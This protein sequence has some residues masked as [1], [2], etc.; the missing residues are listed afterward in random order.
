MTLRE[1]F[2]KCIWGEFKTAG[3]DV[4]Y[5]V[6]Q[7]GPIYR[8]YLQGTES[9]QDVIQDA[10]F[11]A[12]PYAQGFRVHK[13]IAEAYLSARGRI[14]ADLNAAQAVE[15][16][17][18]SLGAALAILLYYDLAPTVAV[19][20]FGFGTPAILWGAPKAVRAKFDRFTR[21]TLRGDPFAQGWLPPRLLGYQH[22]GREVT[23]GKPHRLDA[24]ARHGDITAYQRELDRLE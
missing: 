24:F 15:V 19:R 14:L 16:H 13:G 8:V 3:L 9:L 11:W 10:Q 7:D 5:R 23:I 2:D 4:D 20:G 21:I 17:G 6:A 22:V 18:W 12:T 1:R